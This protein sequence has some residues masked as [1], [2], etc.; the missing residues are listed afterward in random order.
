VNAAT[1]R[2]AQRMA[3]ARCEERIDGNTDTK[4]S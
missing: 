2:E 3:R 1:I 4:G